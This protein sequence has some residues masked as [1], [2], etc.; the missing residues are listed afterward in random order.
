MDIIK[1]HLVILTGREHEKKYDSRNVEA[2]GDTPVPP[3]A[4]PYSMLGRKHKT[5]LANE[6]RQISTLNAG[7]QGGLVA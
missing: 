4:P 1:Q 3:R 5:K 2:S 6:V 7:V